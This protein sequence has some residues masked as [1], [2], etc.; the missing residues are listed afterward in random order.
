MKEE[1]RLKKKQT[2]SGRWISLEMFARVTMVP[3]KS[4][5][6]FWTYSHFVAL[7]PQIYRDSTGIYA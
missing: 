6:R 4:I 5:H 2:S 3:Y 1:K 7:Q